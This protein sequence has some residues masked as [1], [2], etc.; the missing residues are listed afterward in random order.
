MSRQIRFESC[1]WTFHISHG[2]V[3]HDV[4]GPGK[5]TY[6][7]LRSF[8]RFD[9]F[10]IGSFFRHSVLRNLPSQWRNW[11]MMKLTRGRNKNFSTKCFLQH[12]ARVCSAPKPY[13]THLQH[14][15]RQRSQHSAALGTCGLEPCIRGVRFASSS[16]SNLLFLLFEWGWC[17]ILP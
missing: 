4:P 10:S 16:A 6:P 9:P 15:Q 3:L 5:E 1:H 8:P 7:K 17:F 12:P 11:Q 14:L 2:P 13:L